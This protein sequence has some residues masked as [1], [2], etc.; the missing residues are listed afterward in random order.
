MGNRHQKTSSGFTIIESLVAL[1]IV[2]AVSVAGLGTMSYIRHVKNRT[3][4]VCLTRVTTTVERFRSI[5]YFA[6]IGAAPSPG[7]NFPGGAGSGVADLGIT[8]SMMFPAVP[9]LSSGTQP[10]IN[11]NIL[12]TSSLNALLALYNSNAGFCATGLPYSGT[13]AQGGLALASPPSELA[14]AVLRVQILPYST[15]TGAALGC[16]AAPLYIAP[17]GTYPDS[18]GSSVYGSSPA[19]AVRGGARTDAGLILKVSQDYVD[20]AGTPQSCTIE[21][22]FQYAKDSI[23]PPQPDFKSVTGIPASQPN[24]GSLNNSVTIRIGYDTRDIEPGSVMVCRDLS[25]AVSAPIQASEIGPGFTKNQCRNYPGV[26]EVINSGGTPPNAANT[27]RAYTAYAAAASSRQ[28]VSCDRV[29]ACGVAPSGPVTM[30][31]GPRPKYTLTYNNLPPYCRVNIQ[32]AAIDTASNSSLNALTAST[33]DP[34]VFNSAVAQVQWDVPSP[35]CGSYCTWAAP[36]YFQC[37]GCPVY[38]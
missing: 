18:S 7:A 36:Y 17:E 28:W 29:T 22:R 1:A 12:I 16:P 10:T 4:E 14:S 13:G 5:G 32:Y 38:P 15:S 2:S 23:A 31:A 6:A 34:A 26:A 27:G 20:E 30:S 11:N 35:R 25:L 24:C 37:G 8:D 21:Q 19:K 3:K 9:V 33:A